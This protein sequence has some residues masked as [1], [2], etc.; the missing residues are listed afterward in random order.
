MPTHDEVHFDE[1]PPQTQAK[2]RIL[3][4]YLQAYLTALKSRVKGFHYIDAFAGRGRYEGKYA[5]R[6]G[7]V[8]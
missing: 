6:V 3:Q 7:W 4:Q 5:A 2:H 8:E 1:Y